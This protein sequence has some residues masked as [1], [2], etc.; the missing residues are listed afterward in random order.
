MSLLGNLPHTCTAQ[1]RT[2][3]KG[4]L[5]GSSDS[6]ADVTGFV[7]R[8]CW[9]QAASEAEIEEFAKRGI[10]ITNK[11]YFTT[12]PAID[13]KHILLVTNADTGQTDTYEVRSRA[14][15]DASAGRGILYR[16]MCEQTTTGSTP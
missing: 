12:R 4:T 5:G 1:V 8:P 7:D 13:E 9:Q 15:P 14:D 6:F 3:T 16:L 2:R 11:V 10:S